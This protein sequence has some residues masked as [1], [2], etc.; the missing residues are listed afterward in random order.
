[1]LPLRRANFWE[2]T[3]PVVNKVENVLQV[4][5]NYIYFI[6]ETKCF[7]HKKINF[8]SIYIYSL[9]LLETC[10]CVGFLVECE[11]LEE[12]FGLDRRKGGWAKRGIPIWGQM[13]RPTKSKRTIDDSM[14]GGKGKRAGWKH[15]I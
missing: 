3:V 13:H 15:N 5:L 8:Q 7:L 4:T 12:H 11:V 6:R 2:M 1:M 10:S 14:N 9:D